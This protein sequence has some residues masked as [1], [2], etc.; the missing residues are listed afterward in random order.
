[1]RG[2]GT[3]FVWNSV[4]S[5]LRAPSKRNDAVMDDT[6]C[7]IKRFKFVYVGRS[8][9]KFRLKSSKANQAVRVYVNKHQNTIGPEIRYRQMSYI[10]SL[11]VMKQTSECSNV[12]CVHI[13]E[14]YGSTTAVEIYIQIV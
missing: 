12:V 14:L 7:A 10:A 9:S 11:S 3:R 4:K 5:T 2:Y 13:I 6:T 1:M 8:I